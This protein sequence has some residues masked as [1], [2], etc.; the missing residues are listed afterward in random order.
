MLIEYKGDR[1]LCPNCKKAVWFTSNRGKHTC[2]H[3]KQ[4]HKASD[5]MRSQIASA[6]GMRYSFSNMGDGR[7]LAEVEIPQ[8]KHYFLSKKDFHTARPQEIVTVEKQEY[9]KVDFNVGALKLLPKAYLVKI[10]IEE[11]DLNVNEADT[12]DKIIEMIMEQQAGEKDGENADQSE[13][14]ISQ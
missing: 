4:T 7:A 6:R 11:F 9:L 2:E 8:H 3:C 12:K 10:G 5:F 1:R 13:G 14:V